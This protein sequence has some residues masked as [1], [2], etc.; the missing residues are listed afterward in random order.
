MDTVRSAATEIKNTLDYL[1]GAELVIAVNTLRE[2]GERVTFQ[3]KKDSKLLAD[4]TD[5]TVA[6]YLTWVESRAFTAILLDGALLQM[7]YDIE[8]GEVVG[9]RLAYV[10]CPYD[11]DTDLL[12]MGDPLES[13][14][15]MYSDSS[16]YLR[17][18]I[19]FD[20]DPKSAKAMHPE[21]HL[22]MISSSCRLPCIA[23]MHPHRFVDFVFRNFYPHLWAEHRLFFEPSESR[24]IAGWQLPHEQRAAPYFAWASL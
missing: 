17:S 20:F 5:A 21:S 13:I 19:R 6:Q 11:L 23:A 18:P 10:P 1:S 16:P 22:T 7:T 2:D 12:E 9:H 24:N 8:G 14:V 4:R 3:I 15:D